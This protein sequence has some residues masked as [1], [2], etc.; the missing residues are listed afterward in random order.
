[1]SLDTEEASFPLQRR[2]RQCSFSIWD[3]VSMTELLRFL[4]RESTGGED[5]GP[6]GA[7]GP[8]TPQS[9]LLHSLSRT[10]PPEDCKR[11][12]TALSGSPRLSGHVDA[13]PQKPP[14]P[15]RS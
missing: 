2:V 14:L 3:G 7:P 8:L 6:L 4:N 1:M 15:S 12:G 10:F 11:D 9:A 13:L 5:K